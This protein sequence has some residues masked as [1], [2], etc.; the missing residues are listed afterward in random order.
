MMYY[1]TGIYFPD[2]KIWKIH[3]NSLEYKILE[4]ELKNSSSEAATRGVLWKSCS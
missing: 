2:K 1:H 4:E 3:K